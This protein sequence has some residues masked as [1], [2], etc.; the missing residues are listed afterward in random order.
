M[1][2]LRCSRIN[3][4]V[5]Y[6][7]IVVLE[8]GRLSEFASPG[9]LLEDERGTFSGLVDAT[10]KKSSRRLRAIASS[11]RPGA[12]PLPTIA[13]EEDAGEMGAADDS[14]SFDSIEESA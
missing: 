9:D 7:K 5:D 10:G 13:E 12:A 4:I 1:F 6:D 14:N 8:S 2:S 3:T 11:R